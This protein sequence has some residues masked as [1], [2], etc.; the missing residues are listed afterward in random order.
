MPDTQEP[1]G[2]CSYPSVRK[3]QYHTGGHES[4][5]PY[6]PR[7]RTQPR[8]AVGQSCRHLPV[9]VE[10]SFHL[11]DVGFEGDGT[12]LVQLL[13]IKQQVLVPEANGLKGVKDRCWASHLP[14]SCGE[15]QRIPQVPS[16]DTTCP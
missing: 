11:R 9:S 13:V 5:S 8:E 15:N 2:H 10:D 14:I 4:V 7:A 6:H 3:D 1:S 16:P 12:E